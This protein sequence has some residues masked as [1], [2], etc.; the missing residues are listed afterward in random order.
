MKLMDFY[1]AT[2]KAV[3]MVVSS[4]GY[5][6]LQM[7]ETG[8]QPVL[9]SSKR[10]VLPTTENLRKGETANLSYFNP[11][12]ENILKGASPILQKYREAVNSKLMFS[13][14]AIIAELLALAA[15]N[16]EHKRLTPDQ[17]EILSI[18]KKVDEKSLSDFAKIV[19]KVE[20]DNKHAL[21]YVFLKQGAMIGN[22]K[23][24]RG[25]IVSFPFYDEL[26]E[27]KD[28]VFG[29][30]IRNSDRKQLKELMEYIFP[31]IAN[32]ESYN[33]GSND[34]APSFT[35]LLGALYKLGSCINQVLS[36]FEDKVDDKEAIEVYAEWGEY[37]DRTDSFLAEIRLLPLLDGNEGNS[38]PSLPSVNQTPEVAAC[39]Q[40]VA[41]MPVITPTA[42]APAVNAPVTAVVNPAM[43]TMQ[44]PPF[45]PPPTQTPPQ[46]QATDNGK[47]TFNQVLTSMYG[48]NPHMQPQYLPYQ[49]PVAPVYAH[50]TPMV[51]PQPFYPQPP[52]QPVYAQPVVNTVPGFPGLPLRG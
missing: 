11:L 19:Q 12:K 46:A 37:L 7:D 44:P 1:T 50:Q 10:L 15:S 6:S 32:K 4:D 43:Q 27:N 36:L 26:I 2:L 49:Q 13:V 20:A 31:E 29:V 23:Y 22:T 35:S 41:P 21:V 34:L 52:M 17:S 33:Y 3:N 38:L 42:A 9:V 48:Q 51:A 28:N 25:T 45:V 24:K 40:P 5:I 30:K 8:A 16:E 18:L 47:V 14:S 39:T